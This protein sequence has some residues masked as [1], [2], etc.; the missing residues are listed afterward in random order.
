MKSW[1]ECV[2]IVDG[3]GL[4]LGAFVCFLIDLL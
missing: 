3:D 1:G 4:N 2:E